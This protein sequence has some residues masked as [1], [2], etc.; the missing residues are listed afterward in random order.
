MGIFETS[1]EMPQNPIS[2]SNIIIYTW[3]MLTKVTECQITV[4]YDV[5]ESG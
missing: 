3:G 2:W 1:M 4:A 5:H